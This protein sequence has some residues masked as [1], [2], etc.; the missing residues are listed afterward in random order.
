MPRGSIEGERDFLVFDTDEREIERAL[1]WALAT[2]NFPDDLI[3]LSPSRKWQNQS[4]KFVPQREEIKLD[5]SVSSER[6]LSSSSWKRSNDI[7][8]EF[9]DSRTHQHPNANVG[10][11]MPSFT[12]KDK[13]NK[14]NSHDIPRRRFGYGDDPMITHSQSFASDS[15]SA[16]FILTPRQNGGHSLGTIEWK[17]AL[18]DALSSCNQTLVVLHGPSSHNATLS[19]AVTSL[20][21]TPGMENLALKQSQQLIPVTSLMNKC[22]SS[23]CTLHSSSELGNEFETSVASEYDYSVNSV[24]A[25]RTKWKENMKLWD[26]IMPRGMV[27][28]RGKY[29]N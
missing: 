9:S 17:S 6:P 18:V 7:G 22:V 16:P 15:A 11:R 29:G 12:G 3:D 10:G 23:E 26:K 20:K 8:R 27:A 5:G 21:E 1:H 28:F 19:L 25:F 2:S 24:A 13:T 4:R 14:L